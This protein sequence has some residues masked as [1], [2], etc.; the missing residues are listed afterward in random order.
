MTRA[1]L[2]NLG[3]R[4]EVDKTLGRAWQVDEAGRRPQTCTVSVLSGGREPWGAPQGGALGGGAGGDNIIQSMSQ[5][6]GTC[7]LPC[8][9]PASWRV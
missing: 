9:R 4:A 8:C 7:S 3:N 5:S 2:V 6:V 1:R